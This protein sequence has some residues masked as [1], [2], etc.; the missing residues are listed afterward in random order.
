MFITT[1]NKCTFKIEFSINDDGEAN[2][3]NLWGH[4]TYVDSNIKT[5]KDSYEQYLW[6]RMLNDR[7]D[8]RYRNKTKYNP[9][10]S[11]DDD[12][13]DDDFLFGNNTTEYNVVQPDPEFSQE[14]ARYISECLVKMTK[15]KKCVLVAVEIMR[16][17]GYLFEPF[18]LSILYEHL[19]FY[20]NE[21]DPGVL[22]LFITAMKPYFAFTS[23]MIEHVIRMYTKKHYV[24]IIPRRHGKTLIIYAVIAAFLVSFPNLTVL[25]IAQSKNIITN[26]K[27]KIVAYVDFWVHNFEYGSMRISYPTTDNVS[28][29]Y[30][31]ENKGDSLLV[32]VSAHN[33]NS[34]RGPDPQLCIVDETM[35]INHN[36]FNSILALGQKKMCKVGLLSSP[37]PES[38]DLLIQFMTKL[39]QEESG[40]NFY[41]VNYFCGETNHYK[42]SSSQDGCVNMIFYKP[43]HITFTHANK[44]LTEIMTC[45]TTCYNSELGIIREDDFIQA[46]NQVSYD[47]TTSAF[48]PTFYSFYKSSDF[49][50]F[51]TE[52]RDFFIY[53]DPAYCGSTISGV[54]IACTGI[55]DNS[56][57]VIYYMNHQFIAME[58][59]YLTNEIIR[60]MILSCVI[61]IRHYIRSAKNFFLAIEN[62][63]NVANVAIIYKMMEKIWKTKNCNCYMYYKTNQKEDDL[64]NRDMLIPGYSM[65]YDKR[66][67][68][69]ESLA[70]FNKKQV[71]VSSFIS[72]KDIHPV[73]YF[74]TQCR[75]FRWIP[76]KRT[77]HGKLKTE[78][79]SDDLVIAVLLSIYFT[80]HFN[81]SDFTAKFSLPW[82][83]IS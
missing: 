64:K 9:Y 71:K 27:K 38:R 47:S 19:F 15:Y 74:L 79:G 1:E 33:D 39:A 81:P 30:R 58:K 37:T 11:N 83:K 35:C 62:N 56:E 22:H 36:R 26:T 10:V 31:D 52:C 57:T 21:N 48:S 2:N 28:I 6:V 76:V 55:N 25:A 41:H 75:T 82:I 32:C 34:L 12:D 43:R 77:Y 4:L 14:I 13:D 69:Q 16:K 68:V 67:I 8:D 49:L 53:V 78:Q 60:D 5:I 18:Q 59:L 72:C 50:S 45:S 65:K 80:H 24:S 44:T 54:G 7:P 20:I 73:Q 3:D 17:E 40:I 70:R 63:G 46:M 42:Y 61:E 29:S 66:Y 23:I 51:S